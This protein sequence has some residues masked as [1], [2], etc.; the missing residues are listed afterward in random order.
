ML[1]S[2]C[3][4]F[5]ENV[6]LN[7]LFI[8]QMSYNKLF[9]FCFTLFIIL[10][11]QIVFSSYYILYLSFSHKYHSS[12]K[13]IINPHLTAD[14]LSLTCALTVGHI[15]ACS[16]EII[17]DE[18]SRTE[19]GKKQNPKPGDCQLHPDFPPLLRCH[20]E[21]PKDEKKNPL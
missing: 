1:I 8:G 20:N 6:Y 19:K 15:S 9:L 7:R 3:I 13:G 4:I 11:L 12:D 10:L 21:K 5:L 2:A 14:K 17:A 16:A 18:Q